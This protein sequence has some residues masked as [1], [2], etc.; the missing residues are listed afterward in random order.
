MS[1]RENEKL[2]MKTENKMK[3]APRELIKLFRMSKSL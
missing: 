3:N 1:K 2:V